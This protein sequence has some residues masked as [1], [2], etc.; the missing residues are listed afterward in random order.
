MKSIKPLIILMVIASVY[1][2]VCHYS[3]LTGSCTTV[4]YYTCTA[5]KPNRG[6][7]G[8]PIYG[9]C[10]CSSD[11]D[12]DASGDC[13]V[14]GS[15]NF[16]NKALITSFIAITIILSAF[17]IFVKGMKYFLYKTIEDIQELSLIVFIN[18]YFPQQL[19]IFLTTLYRFNIS[20]YTF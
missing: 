9:M 12:E 14:S 1:G 11:A 16:R 7:N 19:D 8:K 15:F 3:C 18:L 10:Y 17:A 6:D 4:D 5:C 13:Q 20:S 2:Q